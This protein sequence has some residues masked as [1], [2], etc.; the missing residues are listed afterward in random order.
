MS[1]GTI[2]AQQSQRVRVAVL[3]LNAA[4]SEVQAAL[5]AIRA[6]CRHAASYVTQRSSRGYMW[7]CQRCFIEEHGWA[8]HIFNQD[9]AVPMTLEGFYSMRPPGPLALWSWCYGDRKHPGHPCPISDLTK[10]TYGG[11]LSSAT[12]CSSFDGPEIGER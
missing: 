9:N 4:E 2:M 5:G 1:R 10:G 3:Q 7:M 8:T 6:D 12:R 11:N